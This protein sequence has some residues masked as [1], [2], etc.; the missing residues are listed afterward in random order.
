VAGCIAPLEDCYEPE[1]SIGA[2]SEAEHR[3]LAEVLAPH[4]DLLLCE[5]FA[6]PDEALAAVRAATAT[7]RP[8]WLALT[9]GP[10]ASLLTPA[11]MAEVARRAVELGVGA[12]LVNCTPALDT[13]R[14]LE[15]T[16][17]CGVPIGAYANAGH[18]DDEIGWTASPEPGAK[19]Y[20]TLASSWVDAG[21]E[22]LGSCCGTGPAH[23]RALA[24]R[25]P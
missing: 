14:F 9:A 6:H 18:A 17:D 13:R 1:R 16:A 11:A 19:A 2:A 8:V 15:A 5:T 3:R 4:C 12:V 23:I 20:A 10:D 25:F 7:G 21:A 24:E 22:I